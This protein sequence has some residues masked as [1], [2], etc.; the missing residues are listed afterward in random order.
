[1][2]LPSGS[3]PLLSVTIRPPS[4]APYTLALE[5]LTSIIEMARV[6]RMLTRDELK[7]KRLRATA[8][9]GQQMQATSDMYDRVI[10]AGAAVEAAR[11]A[12]ERAHVSALTEQLRDLNEMAQELGEFANAGPTTGAVSTVPPYAPPAASPALAALTAAQPNPNPEG[13]ARGDA[14]AGTAPGQASNVT[15]RPAVSTIGSDAMPNDSGSA[16]PL[17]Q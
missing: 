8:V 11:E 4:G 16:T 15:G 7:A 10:A 3:A 1:M 9:I 2:E 13:W 14:Y 5:R 6:L 12:A 17:G